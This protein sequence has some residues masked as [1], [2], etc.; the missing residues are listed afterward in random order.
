MRSL[1][2]E[3]AKKNIRINCI[4]PGFINTSFARDF[5]T[6]RKK[7]YNWTLQKTP[8]NRWGEA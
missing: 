8:M 7:L 6:K 4:A 3:W 2:I 1:A 5:K